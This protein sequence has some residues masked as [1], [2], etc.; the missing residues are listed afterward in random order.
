MAAHTW[1]DEEV[2][3]V[4]GARRVAVVGAGMV[5]LATA[6]FLRERGVEV[7]VLDR[8]GVAAGASWGNAGWLTPAIA[9]PL[10][11][12][13]VLRYGIK[14]LVSPNSPVYVPPSADPRLVRFAAG[15][16]RH[17]TNSRWERAMQSLIPI[18]DLS[19]AAF[20]HLGAHGV[21]EPVRDADPFI[22]AYDRAGDV[23]VLLDEFTHI[24][25]AGGKVEHELIGADEA[26]RRE[27][28]L[29]DAVQA[30]IVIHGQRY[31]NPVRYVESL[32]AA[33]R[34]QGTE[35]VTG[36]EVLQL[37]DLGSAGVR[38]E[39]SGAGGGTYDA[40]VVATGAWLGD[41]VSPFGV[42]HVV[43]A[44]RGYSFSVETEHMPASPIYFPVARLALTPLG[45]RL[46]VAG[47]MEFRRP[48]A[49]LDP[50]RIKA[51]VDPARR[52]LR[53]VDL[54]HRQDEWVG[55]R[56]VTADGL[57]LIGRTSS[58]RVFVAGGH[59]MWGITLGP[60]TGQLLAEQITTGRVPT[61]LTP[62]DP[63]RTPTWAPTRLRRGT[64]SV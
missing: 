29:S 43:Q 61:A 49:A 55:S 5:G 45:D 12:P 23:Q 36:T 18:N 32:A 25:H 24:E 62:F 27:P 57:P 14:A 54:D 52:L 15:F 47:M 28:A 20:D 30:A 39:T 31:I 64:A 4:G 56:P 34:A 22:A 41:L 26:R 16:V 7:T 13:A 6:W 3:V 50:R 59:G 11:E 10:P 42:R 53:G 63:L 33:V 44:G 37:D 9:T 21:D 58:E 1:F 35:I 48:D 40:V 51:L 38:V 8:E 19:L 60:A 17:S 2:V 46:R